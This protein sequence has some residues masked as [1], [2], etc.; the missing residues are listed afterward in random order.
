MSVGLI[1]E[2]NPFHYGHQYIIEKIR[3]LTGEPVICIMSGPFVQRA[4]PAIADKYMRTEAALKCGAAAVIE[5]PTKFATAAARNFAQGGISV[6]KNISGVKSLAFGVETDNPQLLY[7]IAEIKKLPQTNVI[8]KDELLKGFSYPTAMANAITKASSKGNLFK[9]VLSQP[10][11]ILAI[12]YIDALTD[13]DIKPLPIK[14][15]GN[16]YHDKSL[17]NKYAS[18]TAIREGIDSGIDVKDYMPPAMSSLITQAPDQNLFESLVLYAIRRLSLDEISQL[19]DIEPG[20]EYL[21]KKA[22]NQKSISEV[23]EKLKSKRY[24]YARLKRTLLHALLGINMQIMSDITNVKTRVLGV[25][26]EHKSLLSD[27]SSNIIARN[28]EA[29]PDFINDD[30]VRIDAFADDVYALL[31]HS[32]ANSYY[33]H[34]LII[35]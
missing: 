23:I 25:K 13:S 28:S 18:A 33:S 11:N 22:A 4:E 14:R 29:T 32:N 24:T 20:M 5:L 21:I 19:P 3:E 7:E 6:L 34:P 8:I 27:L 12:E 10:N 9:K 35:V 30:S 17:D 26:K 31:T 1:S 2:F 16:N 15:I